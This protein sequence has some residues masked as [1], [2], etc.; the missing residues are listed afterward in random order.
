MN[1]AFDTIDTAIQEAQQLRKVLKRKSTRQVHS[2]EERSLIKATALAWFNNHRLEFPSLPNS[3]VL[4]DVDCLYKDVLQAS[5]TAAT[6]TNYENTL[7]SIL[8][9]LP[10]IRGHI[11]DVL[12][13]QA[14][15]RTLDN[16][17]DFSS[18][19]HDAK[20][21]SILVN[22]WNECLHCISANAP[23]AATVMMGGFLEA[24]L[25]ARINKES[26]KS[27]IFSAKNAPF[28]KAT[29]KV[30][31]LKDWTLRNYIDVAHEL[32]WISQSTKDVSEV[33]RDYRNYIHPY[34]QL[35]HNVELSKNDAVLFWEIT[36]SVS[37]QL[38]SIGFIH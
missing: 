2:N 12:G 5:D 27:K 33:L 32:G 38:L 6:R 22:R 24:L 19:I 36:R 34:K 11:V 37:R 1:K 20:M 7:K 13:Q 9:K 29:K 15:T 28:D 30:A 8:Q 23:L 14:D 25:L 26:D 10:E 18:L 3:T 4:N 31:Q 35:S 17:P 21:Q 16:P